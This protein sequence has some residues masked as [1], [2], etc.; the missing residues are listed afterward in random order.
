[1]GDDAGVN[2]AREEKAVIHVGHHALFDGCGEGCADFIL[3][4]LG[5]GRVFPGSVVFLW[6]VDIFREV[7]NYS[8]GFSDDS[9]I[10]RH[11]YLSLE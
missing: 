5:F 1:M 9:N 11:K 2:S 4:W 10:E 7:G 6:C 3:G 8:H